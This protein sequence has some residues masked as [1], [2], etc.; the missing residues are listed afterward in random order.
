M[1]T[2]ATAHLQRYSGAPVG[3]CCFRTTAPARGRSTL[4]RNLCYGQPIGPRHG[5]GSVLLGVPRSYASDLADLL[6]LSV[7]QVDPQAVIGLLGLLVVA[8]ATPLLYAQAQ[9]ANNNQLVRLLARAH[10]DTA[11][12]VAD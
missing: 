11:D 9:Q 8:A 10:R 6:H 4:R 12:A 2:T 7:V 5:V 3:S 1:A